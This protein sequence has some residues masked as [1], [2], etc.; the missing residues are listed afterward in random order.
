MDQERRELADTPQ[1]E[2]AELVA[3]YRAKG[4]VRTDGA[5]CGRRTH[6]A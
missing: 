6:P 2:L 1:Q 3:L 4:F 5:R